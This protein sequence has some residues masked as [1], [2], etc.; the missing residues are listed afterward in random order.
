MKKN[1]FISLFIVLSF[2]VLLYNIFFA[3]DQ[4]RRIH[5][6]QLFIAKNQAENLD[7]FLKAFRESYQNNFIHNHISFNE[8]TIN[9][10]P[11]VMLPDISKRFENYLSSKATIK[12]VSDNPRDPKNMANELEKRTIAYFRNHR[13]TKTYYELIDK[14]SD[15][16]F[17]FA[18]P[19][20]IKKNCLQCH[21]KKEKAPAYIRKKYDKAY[22]YKI[23]DLKGIIAIYLSQRQLNASLSAI[24]YKN[25]VVMLAISFIFLLI[26]YFLTKKIYKN[27]AKYMLDLEREVENKTR[28]LQ[29]KSMELE[30]RLYHDPLTRLRN[31]NAL[32]QDLN[33]GVPKALI[34]LNIDDFK[35][36]NDFYGYSAGD[37]LIQGIAKLLTVECRID[38]CDLYRM[39]SDEFAILIYNDISREKLETFITHLVKTINNHDFDIDGNIVHLKIAIGASNDGEDLLITADMAMK[40]AKVDRVDYIIYDSSMDLSKKYEKNLEWAEKIKQALE[41]DR[42]VPYFQ[43]IVSTVDNRIKSYEALVRLIDENGTVYTPFYF[44]DIAK[45]TKFYP[46]LTKRMI[47]K[48]FTYFKDKSCD[49]S[50]NISYLDFMNKETMAY[51]IDRIET[52]SD[53]G[54]IHFEILESEGIERYEE[55]SECLKKLRTLGCRISLDDFGSGYS[56]FEHMLK[57]EVDMLKIDGSLIKN[58][59]TDINSQ[60]VVETIINFANRLQIDTCAE[61]VSSKAIYDTVKDLG[62]TYVQGYYIA[63]PQPDLV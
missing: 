52:F 17:F 15:K 50:I 35:Q 29:T 24:V 19:L 7:A 30:Y 60:I 21:G 59:D 38:T 26:F 39:P 63:E 33:S 25:I 6:I 40:K 13:E 12:T 62:V 48:T 47:D 51:I 11:V 37:K 18:A 43:P 23:G 54:R 27:E 32:I 57:L 45:Q 58:I 10:L 8:E 44:L 28:A 1:H 56:S 36:I 55:V 14:K 4:L 49:F 53:T 46:D 42:I 31:R 3:Y 22:D 5:N 9:L 41:E 20:Y 2:L 34:L 61:F 16:T